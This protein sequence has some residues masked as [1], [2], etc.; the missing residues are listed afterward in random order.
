MQLK[1]KRDTAFRKQFFV[2]DSFAHPAKMDAQLLIWIV[3]NFTRVGDVIL[4]PMAGQGTIMLACP[5]GRNVI[6][7]ELEE[8]FCKMSRDNWEL[9]KM[10]PRLGYEMGWC[11][12]IQGD[13]RNLSAYFLNVKRDA[14]I[15]KGA[16]AIITSPPYAESV[17]SS[18]HSDSG[19]NQRRQRLIK[20]G[21]NPDD[22]QLGV[23]RNCQVVWEY[24]K[25]KDNIGNLPYG[26]IDSI[27][28][29]PP[30]AETEAHHDFNFMKNSAQ[31]FTERVKK[32][33]VKGHGFTP[34]ARKRAYEKAEQGKI[35]NPDNVGNLPY[36]NI[37]AVIT[38]PP[39]EEK[40]AWQDPSFQE[41]LKE[42]YGQRHWSS[43]GQY[44]GNQDNIGNLKGETY[45]QAMLEVYQQCHKV[46]KP[47]GLMILVTKN[48][49]RNKQ[50]IRLDSDTIKLCEQAGFGFL[51]RH[52]RKLSSQSFWR[53]I[54]HQKHPEVE[55]IEFEDVLVFKK[56]GV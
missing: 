33:E 1:F 29:S 48:F 8:K 2:P 16:D 51:E 26:S 14:S 44:S 22:Y 34:E 45:L 15:Q 53:I 39:Y 40:T 10:K 37:D 17:Q 25:D 7:N 31:D 55:E 19:P 11:Q 49:I 46:L 23:G 20:A 27:V 38:S 47:Q 52:Y 42:K 21:Y 41:K 28:T 30:Y 6:L 5:L 54:Y 24:G 32:G 13:A 35:E 12:I 56:Y 9:V 36:G 50:I 4:D 43:D 18:R 3:E